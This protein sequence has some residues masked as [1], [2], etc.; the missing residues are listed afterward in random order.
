PSLFYYALILIL[1]AIFVNAY[2]KNKMDKAGK[3]KG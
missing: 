2:L 3:E 1:A